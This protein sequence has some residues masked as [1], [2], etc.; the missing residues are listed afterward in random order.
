MWGAVGGPL[1]VASA[2]CS[3]SSALRRVGIFL[4]AGLRG[5]DGGHRL[6]RRWCP[7]ANDNLTGVAVLLSLARALREAVPGACA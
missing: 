4:C 5:G 7:G 3:G 2:R 6:A 1:L